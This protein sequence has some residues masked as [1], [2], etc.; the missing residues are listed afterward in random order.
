MDPTH[1][2]ER[3]DE[4]AAVDDVE[5]HSYPDELARQMARER[6]RDAD[7]WADHERLVRQAS[8]GRPG[9]RDRLRARFGR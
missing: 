5:G 2:P 1:E 6:A 8:R 9:I 3:D 7:R 4:A